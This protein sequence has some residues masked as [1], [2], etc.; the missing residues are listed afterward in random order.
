MRAS[1]AASS[2]ASGA[3]AACRSA[4]TAAGG[5][6][7]TPESS[8]TA[9]LEPVAAGRFRLAEQ[10][11]RGGIGEVLRAHDPVLERDL[12]VKLLQRRHQHQPGLARRFLAEA[13]IAAR[14]QHPGVPPVHD[15]GEAADGRPFIAM[16]LIEG[17]TLAEL[18]AER[19][20]PAHE[21]PRY[22]KIFEQVAQTVAYAHSRGVVHRDLKPHNIMSGAFGEV[23]LM[24]AGQGTG[25]A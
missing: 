23:Q 8:E 24:G 3:S 19:P 20:T 16:K 1:C 11:G 13:R 4:A 6:T 14:L 2:P 10:L 15:V 12:A 21:L 22:L 5:A 17:R 25:C 18:L 9:A 7:P